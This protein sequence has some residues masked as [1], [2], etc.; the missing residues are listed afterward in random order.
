MKLLNMFALMAYSFRV[1]YTSL[2]RSNFHPNSSVTT[3]SEKKVLKWRRANSL[4]LSWSEPKTRLRQ[5]A[6]CVFFFLPQLV[7]EGFDRERC[8]PVVTA[9][10]C[11]SNNLVDKV[12]MVPAGG[13]NQG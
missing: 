2:A 8:E 6:E 13:K 3:L 4:H 1:V 12:T 9:S 11:S 7:G 10:I 5:I